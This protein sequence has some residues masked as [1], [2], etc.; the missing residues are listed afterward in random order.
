[1]HETHNKQQAGEWVPS[2]E[3]EKNKKARTESSDSS[4]DA[5]Y[6]RGGGTEN[7]MHKLHLPH[8]VTG[9]LFFQNVEQ[10]LLEAG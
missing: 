6:T 5:T 1:M 10:A 4:Q 7:T 9:A 8:N 3:L 2:F